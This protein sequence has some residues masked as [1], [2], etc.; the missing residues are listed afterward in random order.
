MASPANITG[1]D[2]NDVGTNDAGAP[3]ANTVAAGVAYTATDQPPRLMVM[4]MRAGDQHLLVV[5]G[6]ADLC[7]AG[8]LRSQLVEML[9]DAPPSLIIDLRALEF[10]DLRGMDALNDAAQAA[11][12][13][14][15]SLTFR[16][17]S[18]Q[19]SWLCRTFPASSSGPPPSAPA[20]S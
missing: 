10:C 6:E 19:L 5:A 15:V 1:T 18:P 7:T 2:S 14:G 9:S 16:G 13:A 12:D 11:A 20:R 3:A 8:Q 17:M 4:P